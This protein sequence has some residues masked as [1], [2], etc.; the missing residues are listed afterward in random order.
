MIADPLGASPKFTEHEK[1]SRVDPFLSLPSTTTISMSKRRSRH[2]PASSASAASEEDSEPEWSW[3]D[4]IE[5]ESSV[6][7]SAPRNK[8]YIIK[9][10]RA[11]FRG[12]DYNIGD[13]IQV[14]GTNSYKWVG[15]IRGFETNYKYDDETR[16][17][18]ED[19]RRANVIWFHRV[20]DVLVKKQRAGCHRVSPIPLRTATC[21]Y[22][23]NVFECLL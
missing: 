10:F 4:G 20:Q 5:D 13:T 6:P 19:R 12:E 1:S 7:R 2:A 11:H 21:L 16:D 3:S 14:N 17:D 18:R 9:H 15:L 23:S 8:P 22:L